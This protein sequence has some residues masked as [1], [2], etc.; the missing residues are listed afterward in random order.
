MSLK[1]MSFI[2]ETTDLYNTLII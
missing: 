2:I 1:I